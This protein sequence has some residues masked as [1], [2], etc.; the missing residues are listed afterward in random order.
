[1]KELIDLAVLKGTKNIFFSPVRYENL[2]NFIEWGNDNSSMSSDYIIKSL[3]NDLSINNVGS[4]FVNNIRDADWVVEI[5]WGSI[6]MSPER[7]D[8]YTIERSTKIKIDGKEKTVYATVNYNERFKD[9]SG[10]LICKIKDTKTQDY[11]IINNFIGTTFFS[12]VEAT[13]TG[14]KRALTYEDNNAINDIN[15][16]NFFTPESYELTT[17]MYSEAIHQ[18]VLENIGRLLNWNYNN[19]LN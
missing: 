1:M 2:G 4:R 16:F 10:E 3:I 17:K 15:A 19:G 13:Y 18:Q 5:K 9:V 12:K 8:K 11:I 7:N 6:N 14:D